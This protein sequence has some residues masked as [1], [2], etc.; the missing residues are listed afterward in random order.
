MPKLEVVNFLRGYSIF[1]IILMHLAKS[2]STGAMKTA[3]SFG[4]AGVHVFILVS[5]FGLY[6]SYLNKPSTYPEFL[7]KRFLRVY[8]PYL[9]ILPA[10]VAF[11]YFVKN[12]FDIMTLSSHVFLF[13]MF[14]HTWDTSYAYSLWF[15]STIFQFYLFWPIILK[16]AKYK[17][18]L[19]ISIIISLGWATFVGWLGKQNDRAWASFFLQYLWEFVLGMK[20]AEI[21]K[22][23]P[24][25]IVIPRYGVLLLGVIVGLLLTG[26]MGKMGGVMKLY[27][28]IPSL[29]GYLS[30][31][32]LV[33][34]LSLPYVNRFFIY[35]KRISYE[36]FLVHGQVIQMFRG[37]LRS[38]L[39][40]PLALFICLFSSYFLAIVFNQLLLQINIKKNRNERKRL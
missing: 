9:L 5:G 31:A 20:L 13:K 24:E 3:L 6:L 26:L 22:K 28:D 39:P 12:S 37:M 14:S 34:K 17:N 7:K 23:T 25:K 11:Y 15:I 33:Y 18:G 1:T 27:N 30:L 10:F 29:V 32:L 19:L 16:L 8:L 40:T 38:A 35:T 21:F 2:S 4:G 36:W